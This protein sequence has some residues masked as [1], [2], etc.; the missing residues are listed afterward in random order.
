MRCH[1]TSST[2]SPYFLVVREFYEDSNL[3]LATGSP[4]SVFFK[5]ASKFSEEQSLSIQNNQQM[6]NSYLPRT[7]SG[8][9]FRKNNKSL[10]L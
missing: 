2:T 10:K 1:R 3:F 4:P 8:R 7:V 6:Y 5:I 9:K